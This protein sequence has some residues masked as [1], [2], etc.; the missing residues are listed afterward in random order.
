MQL[1][2]Q[3]GAV[4]GG[5]LDGEGAA[6]SVDAGAHGGQSEP[7]GLRVGSGHLVGVEA[8]SVVDDVEGDVITEVAEGDV[9]GGGPGVADGVGE[10]GLGDAEQGD[11]VR[12]RQRHGVARE[13]EACGDPV[14]GA[15]GGTQ[16]FQGAGEGGAL[17]GGRGEGGDEAAGLSEVVDGGLPCLVDV[18]DGVLRCPRQGAFG[19][20]QQQ[21][22]AGQPLGEGVVDL[23]REAFTFGQ[24]SGRV[25]RGGQIGTGGGEFF[26]QAS[27]LFALAVQR[28]VPP[29]HRHRHS[30][31]EGRPDRHRGAERATVRGEAGGGHHRGG[32]HRGQTGAAGQQME[33][34]EVQRE[35]HPHPVGGQGQQ[36][37]PDSAHGGQPQCGGPS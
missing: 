11:L 2:G 3:G 37:Q 27:A 20:A 18:A 16:A 1:G 13:V 30:G 9:G 36:H 10:G 4:A 28:L 21:L 19:S 24:H 23:A 25:L 17:Q 15:G 22:D 26:D 5:G 35:R 33:L 34:K 14:A 8:A 7:A 6:E 32:D 31:A 12:G 29:H